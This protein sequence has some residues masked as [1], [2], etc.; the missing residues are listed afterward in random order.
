MTDVRTRAY[1]PRRARKTVQVA[2]IRLLTA[3]AR[4]ETEQAATG[5][6]LRAMRARSRLSADDHRRVTAARRLEDQQCDG[7]DRPRARLTDRGYSGPGGGRAMVVPPTP[8]WRATTVQVAGLWPFAV[9]AT[10]P[11]VGTPIGTHYVT[12]APVHFDPMSWFLRGY[13]PAPIAFV[14]A[15]NGFGKS[16]LIRRLATGAV[17]NGQ[18]VLCMGDTKP[19]YRDLVTTLGGQVID[20]GY[21]HATINPLAVGALGSV[22]H[23]LIDPDQRRQVAARVEAGQVNIVAGLIELVRGTRVADY[24]ETLLTAGLRELYSHT[25]GFTP[26]RPPRLSDLLAVIATGGARLRQFAEEDDEHSY[27]AGTKNL[28]RSL[29]ALI[30]GPWGAI[31]DRPT[32]TPLDIAAPAV[33]IDVSR[34]PEGDTKLLAA[35]LMVCW[36]EG[37]G[38]I[39]A[40][41]ALADAGLAPPRTFQVVMDEIWRVL[42]AGA[43]MVDRTDALTRLNR[44]LGAG[45]VMCSHT[46][47][48]LAAFDSPAS[49]AK[50]L[51]FFERARAK[52]IGPVGPDEVDRIRAAVS[53]TD[54]EK[55]LLTSWAAPRPPT[56][57]TDDR[58]REIPPGT[59]CFLIKT[60]EA[61]EPGIPVRMTFTPRERDADIHNTNRRFSHLTAPT[62][63]SHSHATEEGAHG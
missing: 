34:I 20:L 30:E 25:G 39:A 11:T 15:L 24:E 8:E 50:A 22:L 48:D 45:L 55:L 36:S 43:F 60:G 33:C 61:G 17:A 21:G 13:L 38:A 14:L 47:K 46:I 7:F 53:I 28:R 4:A 1:G 58:V 41:H 3:Q 54:T 26:A 10:A 49:Q 29:R 19:D 27:R 18:T 32:S 44:G 52:I 63:D 42:G 62:T 51:G 57:D 37:F 12:G 23:R 59:G 31:F 56:D 40:A 16:S 5:R 9:G 35:A 2:G 6:G